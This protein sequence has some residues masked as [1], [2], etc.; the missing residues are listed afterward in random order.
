[1]TDPNDDDFSGYFAWY[2]EIPTVDRANVELY[3]RRNGSLYW[4]RGFRLDE[5]IEA[6]GWW[7]WPGVKIPVVVEVDA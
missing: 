6:N 1:M 2:H 7:P 5:F 4:V 3:Q